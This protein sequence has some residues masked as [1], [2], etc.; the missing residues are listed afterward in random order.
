MPEKSNNEK[1]EMSGICKKIH[2]TS[3]CDN[4]FEERERVRES[5]NE[6]SKIAHSPLRSRR[7]FK[8]IDKKNSIHA[9][10]K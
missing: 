7:I 2:F 6:K 8:M 4:F 1:M 10:P 5:A 9:V 3:Q